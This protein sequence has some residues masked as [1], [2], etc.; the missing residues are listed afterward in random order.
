MGIQVL[1]IQGAGGGAHAE[2]KKLAANLGQRLGPDY[3]IRYPAMPN[4]DSPEVERWCVAIASALAAMT[5]PALIVGHSLG[6]SI[7]LK[8]LSEI[9]IARAIAGIFLIATPYWGGDGWRYEGF[10]RLALR[11]GFA[12]TLPPGAPIFLYHSR[13]DVVVPFAHLGLYVQHLPQ[14]TIRD[15]DGRGHQLNND[16]SEVAGDVRSLRLASA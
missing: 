2:D 4:E 10:E 1:F 11:E 13:D 12:S 16:L 6:A 7:L 5:N 9:D 15:L 8:T 14:A 3:D